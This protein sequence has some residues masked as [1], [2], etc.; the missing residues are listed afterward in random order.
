VSTAA[1]AELTRGTY[2]G[3]AWREPSRT[4][5]TLDP[6]H[7]GR[8]LAH[9]AAAS[10]GDVR[11]AFSAA[12][13]AA[14]AWAA[15]SPIERGGLLHSTADHLAVRSRE[16]AETLTREEGKTRRESAAEIGRAVSVLRWF[17]GEAAQ[18]M[19]SVHP[20][21]SPNTLLLS[22]REPLG[23]VSVI[24][25][26]NFPVA[27]PAWKI[28]PALAFGNTIVWKPSEITPLCAVLLVEAFVDAG[29]PAGV[30][31][32]VT[33]LPAEIGA[34]VTDDREIDA[35]T[36]TGSLA[37]GRSIQARAVPRG[38]KVQLE[39]GG[40]NPVIVLEDADLDRAVELTVRGAMWSAGQKCTAT[41]RALV[42]PGVAAAFKER[43]TE[44]VRVL[45]VGD[46]L[47]DAVEIGPLA[48]E[49]QLEKVLGYLELGSDEASLAV[50]GSEIAGEGH[51]VA[52]TV[53]L[54]VDPE[55]RLGQ[56]EIFGP[57]VGVIDVRD[58]DEALAVANGVRYG[59]SASIFTRDIGRALEFVRGIR[60]GMV[61]V[62][63]ETPGAEPQAPFG[64]MKDSSSHSREQGKAS[65]EFF[66]ELKTVA[67]DP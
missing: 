55:S 61:H 15:T 44:R 4:F 60:A 38:V 37:V 54:D 35:I 16:L 31:N 28:A 21:A 14:P 26:W 48:S 11:D 64:G 40:K 2:I 62:N 10:P 49:A 20:A 50:G 18:P 52:P 34:A 67:I 32:M 41:S 29:V 33:G 43:L 27:I 63:R 12:R 22:M 47:D 7:N 45:R 46:P 1:T 59:L 30:L 5:A 66:T 3:G 58:L 6:A 53:Y 17:A 24:T 8:V 19:G 13:E 51:F 36:F 9:C 56:D 65:A 42:L 23:V 39:T 25:P 57:V